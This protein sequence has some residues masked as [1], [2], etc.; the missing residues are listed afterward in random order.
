MVISGHAHLYQRFTRN[1]PGGQQSPYIVA[2]SGGFAATAPK[3]LPHAPITEG[4]HTLEIDPIVDFGY[5]TVECD[6]KTLTVTFKTADQHGVAQ[7]DT[8]SLDL[9]SGKILAAGKVGAGGGAAKGG[10]GAVVHH[11]G[12]KV[13]KAKAR[14]KGAGAG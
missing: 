10:K 8:C 9:K 7:R 12:K 4:D 5:L 11:R 13:L 2:G 14:G 6:A 1:L 3:Q